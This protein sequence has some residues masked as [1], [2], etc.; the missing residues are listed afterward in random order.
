MKNWVNLPLIWVNRKLGLI[1]LLIW[2]N[3]KLG[4]LEF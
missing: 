2:V 4:Q 1:G 3:E